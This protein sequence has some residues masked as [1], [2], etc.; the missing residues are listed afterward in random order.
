MFNYTIKLKGESLPKKDE[1]ILVI[2]LKML[3][4]SA[5][6]LTSVYQPETLRFCPNENEILITNTKKHNDEINTIADNY[7]FKLRNQ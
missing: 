2:F 7:G 1:E 3:D 5:E 4:F 6:H